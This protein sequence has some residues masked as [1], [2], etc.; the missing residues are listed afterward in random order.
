[1]NLPDDAEA[2]TGFTPVSFLAAALGDGH[3]LHGGP[4]FFGWG[5]GG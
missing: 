4:T 2:T 1:L 3:W 5:G